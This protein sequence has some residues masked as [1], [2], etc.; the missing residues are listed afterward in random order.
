MSSQIFGYREVCEGKS[1]GVFRKSPIFF[2]HAS[3]FDQCLV[4]EDREKHREWAR[5]KSLDS[6]EDSIK[7]IIKLGLWPEEREKS[8]KLKL[9]DYKSMWARRS[10]LSHIGI[11]HNVRGFH[12]SLNEMRGEID[13][14]L[15]E[16]GFLLPETQESYSNK[17]ALDYEIFLSS[18]KSDGSSYF[19]EDEFEEIDED[20]LS[21]LRNEYSRLVLRFDE[22]F[23]EA[24]SHNV[25]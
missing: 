8:L 24:L 18:H 10:K 21:T 19:T 11:L 7:K 17:K 20:E 14:D 13:T 4:D 15:I 23:F 3:I 22:L 12:S 1:K 16:R 2:H 5:S 6:H 9:D 25:N